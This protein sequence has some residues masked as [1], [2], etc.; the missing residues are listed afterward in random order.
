MYCIALIF[1]LYFFIFYFHV[2]FWLCAC[3]FYFFVFF[4]NF[5]FVC[6]CS[7]FFSF[8][9]NRISKIIS[10]NKMVC[11]FLHWNKF[12]C[13]DNCW[14]ILILI[15]FSN[16]Y[17]YLTYLIS[18]VFALVGKVYINSLWTEFVDDIM[19]II[20]RLISVFLI[21]MWCC[22]QLYLH[23]DMFSIETYKEFIILLEML[24]LFCSC[25]ITEFL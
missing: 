3:L 22:V 5:L 12:A 7:C 16:I 2:L 17:Y 11:I 4:F 18:V 1:V 8:F 15:F 14:Y 10:K 23:V 13:S 24:I 20:Y 6:Y 19:N 9:A 25:F 21:M